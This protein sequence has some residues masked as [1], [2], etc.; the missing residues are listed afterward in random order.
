[1]RDEKTIKTVISP[2]VFLLKQNFSQ[3]A[4][5]QDRD[6]MMCWLHSSDRRMQS[7]TGDSWPTHTSLTEVLNQFSIY[8]QTHFNSHE[9]LL[10]CVSLFSLSTV[11]DYSPHQKVRE[12]IVKRKKNYPKIKKIYLVCRISSLNL[13]LYCFQNKALYQQ[14]SLK[15]NCVPLR[16]SPVES[17]DGNSSVLLWDS[18]LHTFI[19]KYIYPHI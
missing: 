7:L 4:A 1:M 14:L 15:E 11:D 16:A 13:F 10:M 19:I 8:C 17:K 2:A 9:C 12:E 6:T 5:Q 3:S 18:F